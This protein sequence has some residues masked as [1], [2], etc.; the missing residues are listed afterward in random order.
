MLHRSFKS[1]K[2]KTALKLSVS[3]IKLLKNKREAQVRQLK[4]ELA[5]L[6]ESGQDRTARIRVEHVIREEKT[7]T[8]YDLIEIYCELIAAR[9]PIIES[10]KNCPVDLKE[11]ISSVI[12]ASPRCSDIPELMDVRKHLTAR[13]GKEFVSAAIELRPNCGVN[14]M[15]VE[16]LSAKAPDGPT[17]M[18][19]LSAIAE[20]HNVKWDPNSSVENDIKYLEDLRIE[21]STLENASYVEPPQV[22]APSNCDERGNP[23]TNVYPQKSTT[24]SKFNPEMRSPGFGTQEMDFRQSYTEDGSTSSIGK[25]N[26]NMEFKDATSAAQAAAESAEHASMAARA[27]AEFAS[28]GHNTRQYS[29]GSQD[30]SVNDSRDEGPRATYD[31]HLYKDSVNSAFHRKSPGM[32]NEQI[33]GREQENLA[34]AS[35][36]FSSDGLENAGK[37]GQSASLSVASFTDNETSG[38]NQMEDKN[39][40]KN[41]FECESSDFL[42]DMSVKKQG[43][44]SDVDFVSGIYADVNPENVDNFVERRTGKKSRRASSHSRSSTSSDDHNEI[45]KLSQQMGNDAAEDLFVTVEGTTQKEIISCDDTSVVFDDS[46]SD[47]DDYQ[48]GVENKYKEQESSL[49]FSSPDSKAPVDPLA[50]RN[51]WTPGEANEETVE[52]GSSRSHFSTDN[53]SSPAFYESL[54]KSAV[55]SQQ[56]DMFPATFDDSNG[57]SSE[58]E[59][60]LDES[61]LVGT[62]DHGLY[63]HEKNITSKN[64]I[65]IHEFSGSSSMDKGNG[66]S[67]RKPSSSVGSD[68]MEEQPER[69]QIIDLTAVSEESNVQGGK[70]LNFGVLTGGFRNKGYRRPPYTKN[71]SGKASSPSEDNLVKIGQSSPTVRTSGSS[72][73][74][75]P[76]LCMRELS[77]GNR[78]PGSG[79]LST[80]SDSDNDNLVVGSQQNVSSTRDLYT[81]TPRTEVNGKSSSRTPVT[82]F[83]SDSSDSQDDQHK[84]TSDRNPRLAS[85]FSRR[86]KAAPSTVRS[87]NLKDPVFPEASVIP[88]PGSGPGRKASSRSSFN[89]GNQRRPSFQTKSSDLLGSSE[90]NG[91]AKQAVSKSIPKSQRSLREESVKSYARIQ[92]SSSIQKRVISGNSGEDSPSTEKTSHVHPKL[93]DYDSFAA[94]FQSLRQG[95]Q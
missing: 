70:E 49:H 31:K 11:A 66:D 53:H 21:T 5:K 61:K 51:V 30:S 23:T 50:N 17:K 62:K 8:A 12:F 6:I 22:Q 10:Q 25:Q 92:Q 40:Q 71:P 84:Q 33:D 67:S 3:R 52:I 46:E 13:Y 4:R 1:S 24:S 38:N 63:L 41:S 65:I 81:R 89:T 94:H 59:K 39:T 77:R 19:I 16:K 15:L 82:Y 26:W 58:S 44:K 34:G 90:Q 83:D 68:T 57:S 45:L 43:S 86:T 14:R 85:G 20:E 54:T 75:S 35:N 95:R 69:N 56:E 60:D 47:D 28:S 36:Q 87:V 79:A 72:G 32:H 29:T 73:P 7:M 18:K 74:H 37:I 27:A 64:S 91:L 48:F 42:R 80:S 88:D 76:E 9:L 93:P 2:C 78:S 55:S